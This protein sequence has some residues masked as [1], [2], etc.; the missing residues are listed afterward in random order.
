MTGCV[1]LSNRG[2]YPLTAY[3][4]PRPQ[5]MILPRKQP[6]FVR[7]TLVLCRVCLQQQRQ[8]NAASFTCQNVVG[9]AG[10]LGVHGF[11]ADLFV[12]QGTDPGHLRKSNLL[13][14]AENDQLGIQVRQQ[15]KVRRRQ[16]GEAAASPGKTLASRSDDNALG[17]FFTPNA[18]PAGSVAA[19]GLDFDKVWL[20]LHIE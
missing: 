15:D 8:G 9:S 16:I 2:R 19:D 13:A 18:N 4:R 11:N 7:C 17:Y 20:E 6:V 5:P 14:T 1:V 3:W 10:R 12:D